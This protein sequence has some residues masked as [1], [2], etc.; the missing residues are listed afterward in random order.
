MQSVRRGGPELQN[1]Y[2]DYNYNF[3]PQTRRWEE[4]AETPSAYTAKTFAWMFLGLLITY[5]VAQAGYSTRLTFQF[6][7]RVP[8]AY[9]ILTVAELIVVVV[10]AARVQTLSVGAA[11]ALFFVYAAL[12]GVVF[13]SLFLV[14]NASVLIAVFALTAVYFGG[15]A[16][17]GYFTHRDL[18]GLRPI[19]F[20]GL[21]FLLVVG[22]ISLFIPMGAMER[23]YC[24]IGI[25]IFLGYT[26]Y[27]TQMIRRYYEAYAYDSEMAAKASIFSALQLYLDFINL[28]LYLLRFFSSKNR[29]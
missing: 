11:R 5:V 18:A 29:R 15:M 2:N 23:I 20:G 7:Y 14:M 10:L 16:A 4:P 21:L 19:L 9:V 3:T 6:L 22:L 25:V 26:A 13:S 12:N 24:L 27:D 1:N 28:F 17:F 8:G